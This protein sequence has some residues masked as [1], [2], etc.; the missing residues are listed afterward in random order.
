[1][2]GDG[3]TRAPSRCASPRHPGRPHHRRL[4][5]VR[6]AG[7]R[8][9]ERHLRCDAV[10]DL[11]R[12]PAGQRHRDTAERRHVRMREDDRASRVG[13]ERALSGALGRRQHRDAAEAGRHAA[14]RP[15]RR[16]TREDHG[17][18]RR[19]V[20]Q[21][22]LRRH[23]PADEASRTP[24]TT[25]RRAAG[26]GDRTATARALGTTFAAIAATRPSRSSRRASRSE[27]SPTGSSRLGRAGPTPGRA[28]RT[29]RSRGAGAGGDGE[30][31][32][33][34]GR[35]RCV[36]A[37]R[38]A[39]R[40]LRVAARAPS[41]RRLLPRLHRGVRHRE[42][43][44]GIGNRAPRGRCRPDRERRGRRLRQT[45]TSVS[46]SSC[47]ATCRTASSPPRRPSCPTRS[48]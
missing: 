41:R 37:L 8:S 2:E 1:M 12:L 14:R 3:I 28:R 42:P 29:A 27:R 15:R 43:V 22:P 32:L 13:R 24:T 39:A 11:Q 26:A 44:E 19:H 34:Q 10:G 23:R 33:R 45:R 6:P 40:P 36:G 4:H 9:C 31:V 35:A 21:L 38:R 16:H 48:R 18:G 46:R 25:S 7:A 47:S 30:R 20:V 17:R 5:R